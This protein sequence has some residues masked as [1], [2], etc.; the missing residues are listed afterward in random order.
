MHEQSAANDSLDYERIGRF[1]YSFLRICGSVDV[2]TETAALGNMPRDLAVRASNVAQKFDYILK[3]SASVPEGELESTL[4]EV[5][6]V[7]T[8][9]DKWRFRD[10][11]R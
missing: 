9:I 6:E 1:I 11:G 4:S 5:T 7:Q 2:L 10:S 8:E 3:N